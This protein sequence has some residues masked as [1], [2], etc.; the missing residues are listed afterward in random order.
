ME[1]EGLSEEETKSLTDAISDL[2]FQR[3]E[4]FN[5]RQTVDK[6]AEKDRYKQMG[7]QIDALD[8]QIKELQ[9]Q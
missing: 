9:K 5:Q 4:L 1:R 7:D 6:K 8:A 3:T 2:E